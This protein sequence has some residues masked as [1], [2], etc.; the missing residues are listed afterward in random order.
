M[1][2]PEN[3]RIGQTL[4]NEGLIT[5]EQLNAALT[6]QIKTDDL[7]CS[8]HI[9]KGIAPENKILEV[10]SRHLDLPYIKLKDQSVA[11]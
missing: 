2:V 10:L 4:V 5:V 9:Q 1:A 6:D 11:S 7:I 3:V 8:V